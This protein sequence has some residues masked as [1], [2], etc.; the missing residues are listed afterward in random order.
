MNTSKTQD[1]TDQ[2][3]TKPALDV[4]SYRL[5]CKD[6]D[7]TSENDFINTFDTMTTRAIA[8]LVIMAGYMAK[9]SQSKDDYID[10]NAMYYSLQT[11]INE[12]KDIQAVTSA[13]VEAKHKA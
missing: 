3:Q 9:T 2:I 11:A 4:L 5:N 8:L 13:Y 6:D 12:I 1:Q 7:I 10:A